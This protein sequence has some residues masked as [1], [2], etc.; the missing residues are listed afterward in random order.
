M[1]DK[2][3]RKLLGTYFW[4]TLA[5]I[6]VSFI[7]LL[8]IYNKIRVSEIEKTQEGMRQNVLIL[9]EQTT[10]DTN[11]IF[12]LEKV[13]DYQIKELSK[14]EAVSKYGKETE[15]IYSGGTIYENNKMHNISLAFYKNNT[16]VEISYLH[17]S[18]RYLQLFSYIAIILVAMLCIGSIVTGKITKRLM[19]PLYEV[20]AATNKVAAGDFSVQVQETKSREF[21]HLV[22]NFNKMVKEL[23]S[24]ETLRSDFISNVS[25]EFKT[26]IASIQGFAR[27]LQSDGVKKEDREEYTRIIVSETE[28]LSKLS[29]NILRLSRL[30][31]QVAELEK[32]PYDLAEQIRNCILI[33]ESEW[34]RKEL[35]LEI[36]L[37]E[38][39]VTQNEE[40]LQQV[41]MNLLQN[42]VK[43]SEQKGR[44]KIE[45]LE[46]EKTVLVKIKD[47]GIGMSEE[48]T[49]HIF[50][51]FF[52]GDPARKKEGNGLGLALVK[53]I[54][55]LSGGII[56]VNS[57][58]GEGTRFCITLDK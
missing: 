13:E 44:I 33:L 28:R 23:G 22:R 55:D 27:L 31:N 19:E 2:L 51:K 24:I 16:I 32:K 40:L 21:E 42:A 36:H 7:I 49:K 17:G 26:P 3:H 47:Y 53:K 35:E 57:V 50:D 54:V 18:G 20:M 30:E 1:K 56:E 34:S 52:Q 58:E 6:G 45:L 46:L 43:F 10:L 38:A 41:W 37:D 12:E 9:M 48:V 39:T 5:V 4:T 14:E 11:Q 25:H 29:S 8:T 15:R